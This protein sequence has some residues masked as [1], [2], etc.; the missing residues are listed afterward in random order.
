MTQALLALRARIKRAKPKFLRQDAQRMVRLSKNWRSSKGGHSKMRTK[1]K[2]HRRTP[3]LGF[4]SPTAVKGLHPSGLQV[5]LVRTLRD[6]DQATATTGLFLSR[7]LGLRKR[8]AILKQAQAKKLPF[9]NVKDIPAYLQKAETLLQSKKATAQQ[10]ADEKKTAKE[11]ALK[12]AEKRKAQDEKTP[13]EEKEQMKKDEQ[14]KEQKQKA[15]QQSFAPAG[16]T[17]A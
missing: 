11:A 5:L 15:T 12:E 4:S 10:R 2:G 9:L 3:S 1:E 16:G 13:D 7:T 8:L 14:K 17:P 6:L